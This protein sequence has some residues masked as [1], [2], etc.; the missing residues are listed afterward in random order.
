MVSDGDIL[1]WLATSGLRKREVRWLVALW[2][3]KYGTTFRL[4]RILQFV[5]GILLRRDSTCAYSSG[6]GLRE[7]I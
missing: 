7:I 3:P 2:K 6:Y 5:D 4:R 1:R